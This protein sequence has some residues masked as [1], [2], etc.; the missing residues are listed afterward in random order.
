MIIER[1]E[2]DEGHAREEL[3]RVECICL[4]AH[5]ETARY[6]NGIMT[7]TDYFFWQAQKVISV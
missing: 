4:F 6:T 7:D 5:A 3:Y 1:C 2:T